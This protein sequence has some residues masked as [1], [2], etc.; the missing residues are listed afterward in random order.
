MQTRQCNEQRTRRRRRRKG[1]R[2]NSDEGERTTRG[3]EDEELPLSL[4][5]GAPSGRR[6]TMR[7]PDVSRNPM[8]GRAYCR[9]LSRE[10]R[11]VGLTDWRLT[12]RLLF[13]HGY[14]ARYPG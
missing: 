3:K 13:L 1:K 14:K 6:S 2:R 11:S 10:M 5:S 8:G 4:P 9:R 7:P 12:G